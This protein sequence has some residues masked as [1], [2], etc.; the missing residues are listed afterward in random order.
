[1]CLLGVPGE[2]LEAISCPTPLGQCYVVMPDSTN[3]GQGILE[4]DAGMYA[5][6]MK[7]LLFLPP[8]TSDSE[9]RLTE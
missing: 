4:G 7:I 3:S 9:K 8:N 2:L 6:S 5:N 1:M